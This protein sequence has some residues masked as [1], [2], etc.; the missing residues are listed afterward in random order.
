M[1]I[2]LNLLPSS[3]SPSASPLEWHLQATSML[4]LYLRHSHCQAQH[5]LSSTSSPQPNL[6]L[7]TILPDQTATRTPLKTHASAMPPPKMA[8]LFS[9]ARSV[10]CRVALFGLRCCSLT[11]E[12]R[13]CMRS[14]TN[15]TL[16]R[17]GGERFSPHSQHHHPKARPQTSVEFEETSI[18]RGRQTVRAHVTGDESNHTNAD[19]SAADP[20]KHKCPSDGQ[21]LFRFPPLFYND[22]GPSVLLS[23]QPSLSNAMNYG[24]DVTNSG[25]PAPLRLA[26]SPQIQWDLSLAPSRPITI[27]PRV[28]R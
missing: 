5:I 10:P 4:S 28:C 3:H 20:R 18:R 22:F 24:E 13:T 9:P 7:Q 25:L 15:Q 6:I 8:S 2:A 23:V 26:R 12:S 11:C 17:R 19:V 21:P 14:T 27:S 16:C 1:S